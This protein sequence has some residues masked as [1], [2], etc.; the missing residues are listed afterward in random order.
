MT[1]E[2]FIRKGK[3]ALQ[4]YQNDNPEFMARMN[5]QHVTANQIAE[6]QAMGITY[7]DGKK[8][9]RVFSEK[10]LAEHCSDNNEIQFTNNEDKSGLYGGIGDERE[11]AEIDRIEQLAK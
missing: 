10:A 8:Q 2:E 7:R 4:K 6:D 1:E 9:C 3:E 5:N 11:Q